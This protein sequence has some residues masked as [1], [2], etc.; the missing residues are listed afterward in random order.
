MAEIT[1]K[2]NHR[3]YGMC[4]DEGQ[5]ERLNELAAYVDS[6]LRDIAAAGAATNESHLLVLTSLVL[7]DEVFDARDEL[8]ALRERMHQFENNGASSHEGHGEEDAMIVEAIDYLANKIERISTRLQVPEQSKRS[9]A[10]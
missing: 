7:A 1:L 4:C 9:E 8:S 5:E 6:R 2:I 3:G 10:A